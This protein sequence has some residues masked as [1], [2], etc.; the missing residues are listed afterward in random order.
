[1]LGN[2]PR[3]LCSAVNDAMTRGLRAS[4][5]KVLMPSTSGEYREV[6]L[7]EGQCGFGYH[8][9]SCYINLE[10]SIPEL[11]MML[12]PSDLCE[13]AIDRVNAYL[14]KARSGTPL[15]FDMRAVWIVQLVGRKLWVVSK[16]SAV[17]NPHRNCVAPNS[18]DW[19]DYDGTILQVPKDLMVVM[20]QPGDWL[21]LPKAVW[22]AT[23]TKKGSISATLAAPSSFQ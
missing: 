5:C 12:K 14:S 2:N 1:V 19:V 9:T 4:R 8:G 13:D 21:H 18:S 10:A 11:R 3:V 20:L 23:Y 22:H 17:S 6:M 15:H 7:P 16:T